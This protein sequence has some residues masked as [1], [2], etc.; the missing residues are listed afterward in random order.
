MIRSIKN[1]FIINKWFIDLIGI[2][3]PKFTH[4][5]VSQHRVVMPLPPFLAQPE[6]ECVH[7]EVKKRVWGG[8]PH[9][10]QP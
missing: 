8:H 1:T 10:K 5:L 6:L 7:D 4:V 2:G 9:V 3:L